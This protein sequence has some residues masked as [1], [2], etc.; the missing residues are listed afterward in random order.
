MKRK[1]VPTRNPVLAPLQRWPR[2]L[3]PETPYRHSPCPRSYSASSASACEEASVQV[4]GLHTAGLTNPPLY[5]ESRSHQD[6]ALLN[7]LHPPRESGGRR[8]RVSSSKVVWARDCPTRRGTNGIV[9][10]SVVRVEF[11][12]SSLLSSLRRGND[13]GES[14][15]HFGS[16][17]R[18][19]TSDRGARKKGT[20]GEQ[21]VA[22]SAR[23]TP[24]GGS[25]LRLEE[26]GDRSVHRRPP[27]RTEGV[28]RRRCEGVSDGGFDGFGLS[29]SS[30]PCPEPLGELRRASRT[31]FV[32]CGTTNSE[33]SGSGCLG[34]LAATS[35]VR[36]AIPALLAVLEILFGFFR[37]R[38]G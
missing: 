2:H 26:P 37:F 4:L 31:L 19:D 34:T 17:L 20:K 33:F 21:R 12:A 13:D 38:G 25:S 22:A 16:S 5:L 14:V 10:L 29:D 8:G 6:R 23:N 1:R 24:G 36:E 28:Q 3:R 9:P 7:D 15:P 30:A 18:W 27:T 11:I 35:P 32:C